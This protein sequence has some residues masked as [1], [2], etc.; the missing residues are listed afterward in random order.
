MFYPIYLDLR[1]R[2]CLVVGGGH[3]ATGKVAGLVDAGARVTVVSP[4]ASAAIAQWQTEGKLVWHARTF[5]PSD[6]ETAFM[7]IAATDDRVLNARVY[8]LASSLQR[9]ANA[10]D[11]LDNCNFIAP[12]IAQAGA[13]QV[14]VSTSGKSPALAKQLRDRIQDELLTPASARL[15]HLLGGWR[16]KVKRTLPTYQVR[17]A[18]WEGVLASDVPTLVIRGEMKAAHVS[19]W[20]Q[21][22]YAADPAHI[23]GGVDSPPHG[24]PGTLEAV[25]ASGPPPLAPE[26]RTKAA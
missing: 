5:E 4:D 25:G 23:S 6:L 11:D 1:A 21:L 8:K 9:I 16:P 2:H 22:M 13:I 10:V 7:I 15:A 24:W 18:F 17:M 14:A 12:A 20:Q 19:V 26:D 3:I